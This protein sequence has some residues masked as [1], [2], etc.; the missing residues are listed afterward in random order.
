MVAQKPRLTLDQT[1][2]NSQEGNEKLLKFYREMLLIRRFEERVGQLY[3][4]GLI[5]GFLH[6]YVGQEAVIVGVEN[7][8]TRED[9]MITSYRCHGHMLMRGEN[10]TR[11]MSELT[12]RS[13]GSSTGKGGSMHM[14]SPENGFF[15]GHGIV[16]A[17]VPI[18]TGIALS[19]K[20]RGLNNVCFTFLY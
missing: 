16:G 2:A 4:M 1:A 12:G 5:G 19:L 18:G 9:P 13:M 15:G 6:L 20:Y 3:G 17:Q 10:I 11:V 7:A 8:V 14:F